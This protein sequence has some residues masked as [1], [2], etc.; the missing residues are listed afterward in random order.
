MSIIFSSNT[1]SSVEDAIVIIG[2]KN[3]ME[4]IAS[5][6]EYISDLYG[7]RDVDWELIQQ[8]LHHE[9]EKHY[10]IMHLFIKDKDA[11]TMYFDITDFYN[12]W[13]GV[14]F[15]DLLE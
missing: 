10:D 1:G 5:E 7:E 12:N 2:A 9:D 8:E 3:S 14:D 6:Y 4:G 13:E 11:V 15:N